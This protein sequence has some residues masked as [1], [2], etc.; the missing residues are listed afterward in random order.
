MNNTVRADWHSCLGTTTERQ[1][2]RS[3]FLFDGTFD[4]TADETG[5]SGSDETNLLTVRS[6][7]RKGAGM[8]D[9]LLVTSTMGMV[10]GVHG[11][12]SDSGP[13]VLLC[14]GFPEGWGG[15]EE[16]LVGSLTTGNDANH[17]SA[18]THDGLSDTWGESDS[19]LVAIFGVTDDDG[20]AAWGASETSTITQ[21]SFDVRD[22]GAFGHG[23][24]W[25]NVSNGEGSY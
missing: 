6:I 11:N 19:G 7:T 17:G 5:S 15:L 18:A 23:A 1:E 16:G 9:V 13:V 10:D 3:L 2:K 8:T 24:D 12:T 14:L 21:L 4:T 20:R 22:N 25:K